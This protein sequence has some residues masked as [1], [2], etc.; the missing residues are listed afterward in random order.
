MV[1]VIK[2][3]SKN[4]Q[5]VEE[6]IRCPQCGSKHLTRDEYRAE[7]ICDKCGLVIE[8]DL[9]DYGPEWRAFDS[10][11]REKRARTGPPTTI[12]IHDKGLST[13]ISWQNKDSYGKSIPHRNRSKI[14][15]LR[16]W[17]KRTR[18]SSSAERNLSLALS[19]LDRMSSRMGLPRT[20]RENAAMTYR[21]AVLKNLIRGR[22]IEGIATAALYAACRQCHVPRTLNEI[23]NIAQIQKKEIGRAYRFIVRELKLKL[24]PTKPQDYIP[25]FCNIL[26]LTSC[27]Q[28]KAIEILKEAAER[29]ITSGRSPTGFAAASI[30]IASVLCGERKTQQRVAEVAGVTEVTVRNR[31]QELAQ[32][33]DIEIIL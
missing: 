12:M 4:L 14:Y 22:S 19:K 23:S 20:V 25:R 18:I 28:T 29:E 17:H 26:N 13:T 16:R 3:A 9:I 5:K 27:V 11:Q 8:D 33:L 2:M 30:Y 10:E 6:T 24:M 15:R 1:M 32:K 21:K 7:L 31:Y